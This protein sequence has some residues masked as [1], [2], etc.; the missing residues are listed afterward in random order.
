VAYD[1]ALRSRFTPENLVGLSALERYG[2]V[3]DAWS[4]VVADRLEAGAFLEF[5]AS[6]AGDDDLAVWQ[7]LAQGLSGFERL[8]SDA[9]RGAFE[10]RVRHL[11]G[12][13]LERLGWEPASDEDERR[14][15][16]R[17]L[18]VTLLAVEGGDTAARRRCRELL[19]TSNAGSIDAEL[20]AAATTVVA[21]TGDD[22]DFDRFVE[23][24]R[25]TTNP[26]EQLRYLYALAEFDH[27]HLIERACQFAF[28]DDVKTQNGPFLLNRCIANR[29][30]GTTAWQIVRNRW[31]EA[32]ERF[33]VNTI[34]R[35]VDS[36]KVL[37][38]PQVADDVAAFFEAHPIPQAGPTLRQVLERQ[39]VNVTLRRREQDRVAQSLK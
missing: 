9:D 20:V 13:L 39:Q 18:A 30:H 26:Q 35:M 5:A 6:F 12:P 8:V 4:A 34:V 3:D 31:H 29:H 10:Q 2:L 33:P 28:S 22:G 23:Q 17:G 36:V 24:F 32:V 25:T 27:A 38:D 15:T 11:V 1:A 21:A 7:A 19:E 37:D 14:R 16:L